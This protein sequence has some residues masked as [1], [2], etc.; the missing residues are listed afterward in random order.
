MYS[1]L[2]LVLIATALASPTTSYTT[3]ATPP[4]TEI[5]AV[6]PEASER[7]A[8]LETVAIDTRLTRLIQF[9]TADLRRS[10]RKSKPQ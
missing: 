5:V 7:Q 9:L 6:L 3:T 10:R 4:E 2:E 8:I 1:S